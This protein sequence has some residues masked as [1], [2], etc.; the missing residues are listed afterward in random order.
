MMT[1]NAAIDIVMQL[2]SDNIM[3]EDEASQD[4]DV[5]EPMRQEQEE[6]MVKV[7]QLL[8]LRLNDFVE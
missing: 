2:A 4:Y 1:T 5:L 7:W 6:A 3:S 8:E